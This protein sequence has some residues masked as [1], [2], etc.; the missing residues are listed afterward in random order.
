MAKAKEKQ[1]AVMSKEFNHFINSIYNH[2]YQRLFLCR[3]T[4]NSP[5]LQ[6][7]VTVY[8]TEKY[9]APLSDIEI[10]DIK[11]ITNTIQALKQIYDKENIYIAHYPHLYDNGKL[12]LAVN[13]FIY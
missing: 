8:E 6:C 4:K 9:C 11:A 3:P 7:L 12:F 1:L 2:S 5:Q 13:V 10:T